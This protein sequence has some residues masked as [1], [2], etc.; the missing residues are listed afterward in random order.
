MGIIPYRSSICMS[1]G[2]PILRAVSKNG[3]WNV[4]SSKLPGRY[5]LGDVF[6]TLVDMRWRWTMIIILMGF[7]GSYATFA[8]LWWTIAS[9]HGDLEENHLPLNQVASNWTPCVTEIYDFWSCF[10]FSV[11][12]QHTI[13]F[14]SKKP[15]DKCADAIFLM[16]IQ[17]ISGLI[18]QVFLI[19]IIFTKMTRPKLRAN[20]I[21]FSKFATISMRDEVLCLVFRIADLRHKSRILTPTINAQLMKDKVTREGESFSNYLTKLVVSVDESEGDFFFIWPLTIVHKIDQKSPLHNVSFGDLQ[22]ENFEI[23]V[24]LEGTVES[25]DQKIQARSSYLSNEILW[26]RRF[27]SMIALDEEKLAYEIDYSKFNSTR[28]IDTPLCS[29]AQQEDQYRTEERRWSNFSRY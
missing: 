18:I 15:T 23:I 29:A 26:G 16:C 10:L 8:S 12:T 1:S 24:A 21:Q 19:G 13:G 5:L 14:G 20:C 27:E 4:Q 3:D 17:N 2:K 7:F 25:T 6:L 9:V 22:C 28:E 11:E